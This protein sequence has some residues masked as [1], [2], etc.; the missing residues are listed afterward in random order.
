[1]KGQRRRA[2]T[3]PRGSPTDGAMTRHSRSAKE[4]PGGE[5]PQGDPD[6]G[7][8]DRDRPGL[9]WLTAQVRKKRDEATRKPTRD[10]VDNASDGF[11][12]NDATKDI[13]R[14]PPGHRKG[15]SHERIRRRNHHRDQEERRGA[16]QASAVHLPGAAVALIES[17]RIAAG[18]QLEPPQEGNHPPAADLERALAAHRGGA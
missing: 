2:A 5:V 18:W 12:G 1:M 10:V 9:K 6:R 3:L 7:Q 13:P 4:M 17:V 8:E 11:S 15:K 14:Q 16:A